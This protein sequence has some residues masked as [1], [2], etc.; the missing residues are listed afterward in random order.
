MIAAS[1]LS[2]RFQAPAHHSF[3]PIPEGPLRDN[4]F[5][6]RSSAKATRNP[7]RMRSFKT[8]DL[9]PF[10]ICSYKKTGAGSLP[11]LFRTSS[12]CA[13]S[14]ARNP[15]PL[16]RLLTILWIPRGVAPCPESS[17]RLRARHLP[18]AARG[19]ILSPSFP[20]THHSLFSTHYSLFNSLLTSPI[21]CHFTPF[22]LSSA[23]N[24]EN[25]YVSQ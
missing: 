5:R 18:R 21:F 13:H 8:Q 10:R 15:F 16:M 12:L 25:A 7:F 23:P 6:M 14:N 19:V 1:D 2:F 11:L 9:K 4:P 20:S 22:L 3:T 17:A 24:R